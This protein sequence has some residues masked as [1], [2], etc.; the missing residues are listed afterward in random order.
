MSRP[1]P[2]MPRQPVPDFSVPLVDGGTW[3]LSEQS[4]ENFTMLVVYRGLH[5]PICKGYLNDLQK[6]LHTFGEFGVTPFVV[7]SDQRD[8][9]VEAKQSWGLDKLQ[10]GYGLS[11][12][13]GRDLGLYIS[14]SRGKTSTGV[15]E[16]DLFVEPGLFLIK[17]DRTLYFGSVQTMPFARPQ[18]AEIEGALKFVLANDYPARGEVDDIPS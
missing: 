6:R 1:H 7:S 13:Q 2:L 10:M 12:Q 16:P 5:C 8:R 15:V 3:T 11:L 9:A 17:P 4:P 14:S 18:F